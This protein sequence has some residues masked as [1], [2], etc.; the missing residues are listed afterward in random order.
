[1]AH[2]Y[3][4][5]EDLCHKSW[6]VLISPSPG[7]LAPIMV[8]SV[9]CRLCMSK[10]DSCCPPLVICGKSVVTCNRPPTPVIF[11][12]ARSSAVVKAV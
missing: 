7:P 8:K 11:A 3:H 9:Q 2:W 10:T 1:M 4:G 6:Q 12:K 5:K